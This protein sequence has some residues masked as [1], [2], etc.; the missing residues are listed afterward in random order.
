MG[1]SLCLDVL[2]LSGHLQ[3]LKT[4]PGNRSTYGRLIQHR[5]NVPH[6][7]GLACQADLHIQR[8]GD[9]LECSLEASRITGIC[10][11]T[12]RNLRGAGGNA[13]ARSLDARHHACQARVLRIELNDR[14][15]GSQVDGSRLYAL[16]FSEVAFNRGNAVGAIHARDGQGD[17]FCVCHW[18]S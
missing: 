8:T 1:A 12:E 2:G 7:N 16:H 10:K 5:G 14:T 18:L 3:G 11:P 9:L 13:L 15:L 17:L 4:C 6:P